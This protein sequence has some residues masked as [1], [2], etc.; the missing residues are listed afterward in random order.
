[1]PFETKAELLDLAAVF[2]QEIPVEQYPYIIEHAEQH[3]APT[4][5]D[6]ATEF[7][8]GL[9]LI[10]DGLERIRETDY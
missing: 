8:F 7:E 2:L 5:P 9:D 3:L 4:S 10:V 1:M 6:G